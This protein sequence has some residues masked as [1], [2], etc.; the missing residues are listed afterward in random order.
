MRQILLLTFI[1]ISF[2]VGGQT[3]TITGK[4]ID[5][6]FENL[7]GVRIQN[8]DTIQFGTTDVN[9]EFKI[10]IPTNTDSLLFGFIGM[11]WTPI[12]LTS[13]CD[14]LEIIMI[15]SGTFHYRSHKKIDRIRKSQFD[16]VPELHS[17]AFKEGLFK[18]RSACYSREFIPDKPQLDEIRKQLRI[19][20][21]RIK[22][23]FNKL[24]IGDTIQV[25]F[26]GTYRSD[27]TDRTTLTPWAYF[28]DATKSQCIIEGIITNKDKRNSGNNIE[29]KITDC[30]SCKYDT[31]IIYQEKDMVIG[32]I[33]RHNMK[34]LKVSSK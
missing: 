17:Q 11:E 7:P 23:L 24:E 6:Y 8:N 5:E 16:K 19:E 29:I 14:R 33:F 22:T 13:T 20:S 18:Y 27:G 15:L 4:V 26:S 21:K 12:N 10:E 28:T 9:G 1:V 34:I 31:P 32:T 3:R 25:P 30:K 2:S